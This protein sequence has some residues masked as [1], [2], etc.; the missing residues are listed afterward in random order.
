MKS[1]IAGR[2]TFT[3]ARW[4]LNRRRSMIAAKA[5]IVLAVAVTAALGQQHDH[6]ADTEPAPLLIGLGHLH[7][8]ITTSNPLAQ[9]YFDQGLTLV[10]GYNYDEAL[11]SFRY[12]TKL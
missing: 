12:A 3:F 7:H 2:G 10:Y 11:R 5:W 6:A 9:R 1:I 8:A 4:G